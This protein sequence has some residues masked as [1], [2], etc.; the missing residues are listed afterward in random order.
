MIRLAAIAVL[1]LPTVAEAADYERRVAGWTVGRDDMTCVAIQT[2]EGSGS[3]KLTVMRNANDDRDLIVVSNDHWS[4][5]QDQ[6]YKVTYHVGEFRYSGAAMGIS[7]RGRRGLAGYLH[8]DFLDDFAKGTSLEIEA[9]GT[10]VDRLRLAGSA[11]AVAEIRRCLIGARADK[12]ALDREI[13]RQNRL[14]PGV[15]RDPFAKPCVVAKREEQASAPP[16]AVTAAAPP[17]P[18][19]QPQTLTR[20]GANTDIAAPLRATQGA[21]RSASGGEDE[22]FRKLFSTWQN[23]QET[24]TQSNLA[25]NC[26]PTG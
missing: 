3:T 5:V 12:V 11:A 26:T 9:D 15:P 16:A 22:Q 25:Q 19:A 20:P 17:T 2:Y 10:V 24:G 4:T 8:P 6:P 21:E 23:F 7:E 1:A 18:S 13:A 14:P